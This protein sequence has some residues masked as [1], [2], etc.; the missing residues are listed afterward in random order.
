MKTGFHR[1]AILLVLA[2]F[3]AV[4]MTGAAQTDDDIARA[5]AD[6]KCLKCHSRNLKKKL[7]DGD[8]LSL[9]IDVEPFSTSVHK[10]IGCTGC[11]RDVAKGKHPS[12]EPITSRRAYSLKHNETCSQC[13]ATVHEEYAG[14]VHAKLVA[15]GQE[16]AP[17]CSDCH[18]AHSIQPRQNYHPES[19]EPCSKCHKDVYDAYSQS[20]HGVAYMEGNTIRGEFVQ[21]PVCFNCHEA[22]DVAS[23]V[24]SEK[25]IAQCTSC[26]EVA[27]I[28]HDKWLPNAAMHLESVSCPA[29]HAP[30]TE[31]RIDLLLFDQ[32]GQSAASTNEAVRKQLDEMDAAGDA[33]SSTEL[34]KLM[35]GGDDAGMPED[36]TL[37]ARMKVASGVEAHLIAPREQAVRSCESCHNQDSEAFQNVTVSISRPDGTGQRIQADQS[38]LSS[39]ISVGSVG[40]FYAPGGTRIVLLDWLLILA[41][42]AGL[43]V[44]VGHILLGRIVRRKK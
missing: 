28:A 43:A 29:C 38:V 10:V 12:R 24:D 44:P 8:T 20:V 17:V 39:P 18:S 7:E 35:R 25:V 21:A 30:N 9:K 26:H 3:C 4:P 23:T 5:D 34:W 1:G 15:A 40:G 6:A 19:G 16:D 37:R 27:K 36:V 13:H 31:R 33:L 41:I 22:H 11:H 2:L 42:L 14:S 32:A